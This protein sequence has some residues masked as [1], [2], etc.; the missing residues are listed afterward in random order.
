MR[1][2]EEQLMDIAIE[3][4]DKVLH[5]PVEDITVSQYKREYYKLRLR[6]YNRNQS[7]GEL[8]KIYCS[9]YRGKIR[10]V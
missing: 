1:T 4:N 7:I 3:H 9:S 6:G 10:D 5:K 2:L 8:T